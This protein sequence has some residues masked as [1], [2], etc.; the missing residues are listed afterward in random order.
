MRLLQVIQERGENF[1]F[2]SL[3]IH[4]QL[5]ISILGFLVVGVQMI[6]I[7]VTSNLDSQFSL[8]T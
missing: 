5:A 4:L 1:F 6:S 3:F 2:Y 8:N 7:I